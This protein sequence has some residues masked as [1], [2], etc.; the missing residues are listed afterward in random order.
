MSNVI[1]VK[2]AEILNK[3]QK[4]SNGNFLVK[5]TNERSVSMLGVTKVA[6]MTYYVA[7]PA[8]P[9]VDSEHE[10]DLDLFNVVERPYDRVDDDG[11]VT[12]LMLKWLH[13][14]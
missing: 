13:I 2:V 12:T 9:K 3:G 5:I 14:K 7:L 6:K 4:T 11:V 10:L 1:K 8:K